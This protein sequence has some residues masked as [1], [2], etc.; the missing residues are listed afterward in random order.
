MMAYAADFVEDEP[1]GTGILEVAIS[2][3]LDRLSGEPRLLARARGD[4]QLFDASRR[5]PWKNI[6]G[7]DWE[8]G[9]RVRWYTVE[10]PVGG[11]LSPAGREVWLYSGGYYLGFYAVGALRATGSGGIEDLSGDGAHLVAQPDE[12]WGLFGPGHCSYLRDPRL[13]EYLMLHAR[14][15][16]PDT[17]RQMYLAPLLWTDDDRPYCP[18]AAALEHAKSPVQDPLNNLP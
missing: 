3:D 2:P 18:G 6:P 1:L 5:M 15:A 7:V 12:G 8:R 9:D 13:G 14:F 17:P 4:W 11:L 16:N 10:G